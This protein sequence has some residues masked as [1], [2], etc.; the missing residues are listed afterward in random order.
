MSKSQSQTIFWNY[1]MT[2]KISSNCFTHFSHCTIHITSKQFFHKQSN[3]S[4]SLIQFKKSL[5][6]AIFFKSKI[7]TLRFW[8]IYKLIWK[9]MF[10]VN[11]VVKMKFHLNNSKTKNID[12]LFLLQFYNVFSYFSKYVFIKFV[13]FK[14]RFCRVKIQ[15]KLF[16]QIH[17]KFEILND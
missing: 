17:E 12:R 8:L 2:K 14:S 5:W 7:I 4:F 15:Q 10:F 13:D 11:F 3:F 16:V 6:H 9:T 1:C